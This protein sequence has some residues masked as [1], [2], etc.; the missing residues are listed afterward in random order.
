MALTEEEA[1]FLLLG[2]YG[3][4]WAQTEDNL[5]IVLSAAIYGDF[6]PEQMRMA[7]AIL[8]APTSL[9]ARIQIVTHAVNQF[10]NDKL[11]HPERAIAAW[12]KILDKLIHQKDVRNRIAHGTIV[13][14]KSGG[15]F[16]DYRLVSP[17]MD[18]GRAKMQ[19]T[20]YKAIEIEYQRMLKLSSMVRGFKSIL[21]GS[22]H[23][24]TGHD[25]ALAALEQT[26]QT[27]L[28]D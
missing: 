5:C 27:R 16:T 26:I 6:H 23:N 24:P 25:E 7:S 18:F 15:K 9:D 10:A 13:P 28:Q 19:G 4:A 17:S 3:M 21:S 11:P 22:I 1:M 2:R 20:T 14:K 8:F 12:K